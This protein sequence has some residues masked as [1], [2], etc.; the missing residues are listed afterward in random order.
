MEAEVIKSVNA[1]SGLDCILQ[2]MIQAESCRSVNF[3][4]TIS[5]RGAENCDLLEIVHSD[6]LA[7]RLVKNESYDYLILLRPERVSLVKPGFH[8]SDISISNIT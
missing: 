7:G 8:Y 4:K 6:E 2:C 3:R 1:Q 5:C